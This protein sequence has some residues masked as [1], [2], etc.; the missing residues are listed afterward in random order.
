MRVLR[1]MLVLLCAVART[2]AGAEGESTTTTLPPQPPAEYKTTVKGI[3]PDL[4]GRWV[5]VSALEIPGGGVRTAVALLEVGHRDGQPDVRTPFVQLPTQQDTA[6][7]AASAA[8]KRWEPTAD[9]LAT[10]ARSWDHLEPLDPHPAR[11]DNY[12]T[13]RDAFDETFT[14]DAR[15]RDAQWVLQQTEV[16]DAR[17]APA[18]RQMNVFSTLEARDAG[19]RGNY[20]T[21]LLAVAPFPI[22]ITFN[23]T[24]ELIRLEPPRQGVLTRL[25]DLFRGCRH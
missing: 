2:R 10:L 23:G 7:E 18:V 9:D 19:Y 21:T 8:G 24:F 20:T 3:V 4:T 12:L 1:A 13:G 6:M 11:V 14:S 17:S 5:A 15:V 25:A 16:F 22:P